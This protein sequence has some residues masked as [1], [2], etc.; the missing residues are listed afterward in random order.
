MVGERHSICMTR[1]LSAG[2]LWKEGCC[3]KPILRRGQ[4]GNQFVY[5]RG[6]ALRSEESDRSFW[7]LIFGIIYGVNRYAG[8]RGPRT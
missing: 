2:E 5:I 8:D 4:L 3:D 7:L 1:R 6:N